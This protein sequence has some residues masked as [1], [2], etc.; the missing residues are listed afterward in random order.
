MLGCQSLHIQ[1]FLLTPTENSMDVLITLNA[2]AGFSLWQYRIGSFYS[3]SA[4]CKP[5][6]EFVLITG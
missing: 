4:S 5:K 6:L 3:S 1:G 2:M